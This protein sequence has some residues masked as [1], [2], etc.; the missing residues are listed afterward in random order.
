M[1]LGELIKA[2]I[3]NVK[4]WISFAAYVRAEAANIAGFDPADTSQT[5]LTA[6]QQTRIDAILTQIANGS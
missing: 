3:R 2:Y 1:N 4:Y 6:E 5:Q